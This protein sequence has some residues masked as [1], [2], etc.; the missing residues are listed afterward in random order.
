[1]R[2]E[3][4]LDYLSILEAEAGGLAGVPRPE[5]GIRRLPLEVSPMTPRPRS[6]LTFIAFLP[7]VHGQVATPLLTPFC[8]R[9]C[10]WGNLLRYCERHLLRPPD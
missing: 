3:S 4:L 1:M 6:S 8:A 9:P 2:G 7:L 10:S 5:R